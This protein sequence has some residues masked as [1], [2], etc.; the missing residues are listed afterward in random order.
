MGRC[1]LCV[2]DGHRAPAWP[3]PLPVAKAVFPEHAGL[4]A[5][6]DAGL[7]YT[8]LLRGHGPELCFG[9][10][11]GNTGPRPQSNPKPN[12]PPCPGM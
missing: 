12:L 9:R 3:A 4:A 1:H 8:G 11:S 6:P 2:Q 10:G 5:R 7:A